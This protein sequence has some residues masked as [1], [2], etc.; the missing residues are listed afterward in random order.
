M[1]TDSEWQHLR[2][3][4]ELH[5]KAHVITLPSLLQLLERYKLR[6]AAAYI[7]RELE[8]F[9]LSSVPGSS[10]RWSIIKPSSG[11]DV[12][13]SCE[14]AYRP[15]RSQCSLGGYSKG[16]WNNFGFCDDILLLPNVCPYPDAVPRRSS[17]H[18]RCFREP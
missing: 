3:W 6:L 12:P 11:C 15:G 10:A 13:R 9:Q 1:S 2:T 7:G 18:T 16:T 8:I 17:R 5:G 4:H 14:P